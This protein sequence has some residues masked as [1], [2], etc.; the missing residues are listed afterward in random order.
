MMLIADTHRAF[1]TCTIETSRHMGK[2]YAEIV[3]SHKV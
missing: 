1:N 2:K 3:G